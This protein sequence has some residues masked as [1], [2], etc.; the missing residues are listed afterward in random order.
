MSIFQKDEVTLS[1]LQA[2]L[3]VLD[4]TDGEMVSGVETVTNGT[5]PREGAAV[6]QNGEEYRWHNFLVC[7]GSTYD[8]L[9]EE[10]GEETPISWEVLYEAGVTSS[11]FERDLS[12]E[13]PRGARAT[14]T[15]QM[16]DGEINVLTHEL[17]IKRAE[18]ADRFADQ[19]TNADNAINAGAETNNAATDGVTA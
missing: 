18:V 16:V 19:K 9:A 13:V 8:Q 12:R 1:E 7:H 3:A 2:H 15:V 17:H 10:Y 14:S 4:I 5:Y 6:D 11:Q